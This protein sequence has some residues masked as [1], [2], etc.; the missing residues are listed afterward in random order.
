MLRP[1]LSTGLYVQM[2]GRGTRKADGKPDCLILDFASNVYR[3]GPVDRGR[4][5]ARRTATGGRSSRRPC[6]PRYVRTAMSSMRSTPTP[7]SP[8]ATNGRKPQPE[9]KHATSADA[10]PILSG[11]LAWLPVTDVS[12]HRHYK[13][14]DPVAPPSLRVEYL[15]GLSVYAEY[16]SLEHHGY[17]AH[18]RRALV[19]CAWAAIRAGADDGRRGAASAC[20]SSIRSIE[21]AVVRNGKFWNVTERRVRRADGSVSRSTASID[22]WTMNRARADAARTHAA[23]DQRCDSVLM[24]STVSPLCNQGTDGL[25]GLPAACDMA[26]LRAAETAERR[27]VI[28]LCDDNGCHAARK[29]GSTQCPTETLDAYEI[30]AVLEA[31]AR[32]AATSRRSA[33]PISR[34]WTPTNGANSCAASFVGYEHALRRKILDQ[35]ATVLDRIAMGAYPAVAASV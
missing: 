14:S 13:Y 5:Q 3:H 27:P 29:E 16:V 32:P 23:T 19:V 34:R 11:E 10:V 20:T 8:A 33:R 7:A 12:F 22:C 1:T 30:G 4:H 25:R 15:C 2:V 18:V 26:R 24:S 28:W 35:R 6:A 17:G 21:I 31:G 9:A